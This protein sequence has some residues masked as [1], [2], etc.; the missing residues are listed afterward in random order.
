MG[1]SNEYVFPWYAS[2]LKRRQYDRVCVLG[3][4]GHNDFTQSIIAKQ[5]DFFDLTLGNWKINDFTWNIEQ[6]CY[7]L[8]ICTRCAYFA[9]V[10][11][12]FVRQCVNLLRVG[13]K[14]LIDWGLGDHWR[15]KPYRIGWRDVMG[16][17]ESVSFDV[18]GVEHVSTLS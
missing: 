1:K 5:F 7:D 9:A 14:A 8:V 6:S 2:H 4:T 12:L 10:P 11:E 17:Q 15:H 3:A 16:D 18:G 13:G